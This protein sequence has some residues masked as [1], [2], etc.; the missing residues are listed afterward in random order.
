MNKV[1]YKYKQNVKIDQLFTDLGMA[2]S[3]TNG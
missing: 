1:D 3:S 2:D